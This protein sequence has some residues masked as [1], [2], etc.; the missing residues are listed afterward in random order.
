VTV[1]ET[2]W[3]DI[4]FALRNWRRRPALAAVVI[5]TVALGLSATSLI[6]SVVDAVLLEPLPY[7]SPE[8]LAVVR[9]GLPGQRQAVA[10]LSGPEVLALQQRTRTVQVAGGIWARPGVL[11]SDESAIEIEVGWI[12]PGLLES[13]DVT[14]YLGRLPSADEHLRTDVIVLSDALW[15]GRFG[16][17]RSI[18]GRRIAF[19]DELRTVIGVMPRGFRMLFPPEDG[20]PESME[21]WLPWGRNLTE[22]SRGFRIFTV[23]AR[24]RDDASHGALDAELRSIAASIAQES[25]E[26]ARSGFALTAGSLPEALLSPVRP[27]L[28]VLLGVVGL[29]F[30]IA[31]ANVANLLLIR[32]MER[33]T[34][35]AIRLA[36]GA[37]RRRLWRQVLTESA[38]IGI[39]GA[40]L[41]LWFADL[42]VGLLR[43]LNPSGIPRVQDASVDSG[44][45]LAATMAGVVAALFF[46]W[47][48]ARY[49]VSGT[50][51]LHQSTRGASSRTRL[52]QRLLV[53]A[54]L[55][56]SV[57]LL[58]GA[59]LLVRSVRMLN[60]VD[61][62]FTPDNVVSVRLS[63]PD[64]R[65]RYT[66][67][68]PAI[69]E[70]YRRLDERL[71]ALPG[72]RAVGSTLSPP[73]AGL[74]MRPRPY[75]YRVPGG[76]VEWGAVAA[77]YRTVT[78]GWFHA[79]GARL[80]SGRFFDDRDRWDRPV[81]VIVDTALAQKAWPG[82]DAVG[83]A[84]R[85]ELFRNGVF[86]PHWGEVVG[87]VD[88]VRLNSLVLGQREQ[89]YIA[90]HQ[91]PQR[92]M[93]PAIRTT[94]DPLAVV[95]AVQSV[96]R[97]LEPGLPVFDVRLATD[98]VADAMAQTRFAMIGLGIFGGLAVALAAAGVFAAMAA[99]VGQR[100]REI[101]V[102]LALGASPTVVFRA[103]L[104]R[105]LG[106]AA[107][108]VA[109][110]VFE[111][112][113]LT[114]LLSNL[115]FG[116]S[117]TDTAT[118][119]GVALLVTLIAVLACSLPAAR[120]ARVDPCE[121][122][123]SE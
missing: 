47:V 18:I 103:T 21:A 78:P 40:A 89:V 60:A 2:L 33:S 99:S 102:R 5:V 24:L 93:Y 108:G 25:V 107:I 30:A 41:G 96:V 66:T 81:A 69:A 32:S 87:V 9:A 29:V 115:L 63:L 116:V 105:G 76:E 94:G 123:R 55:S 3:Q 100:R 90:H 101:G 73:L 44:T 12:T 42:G 16:G 17:D 88:S 6:Y 95:A 97:A 46:G 91:S 86:G 83:Q 117:P 61:L 8:R 48:A 68:G 56:L 112:V 104:V 64:L 120:A 118:L 39:G 38:L 122:L 37:A 111:A 77:D 74:P 57:V 109:A 20:V 50:P 67:G 26:Y 106:L 59:G 34:E 19:D 53:V 10:Q 82:Q 27:T 52:G 79:I 70:F 4:R 85:V 113:V 36:L 7:G 45:V 54:Q 71:Q 31:C 98:Y 75:A 15:R 11:G 22:T 23:V 13:L 80:Q 49:A 58:S 62:G 72:V 114:R 121:A 14:P 28:L 84:V 65:Y 92:T 1:V 110:G 35:F 43:Q 119:T 51:L